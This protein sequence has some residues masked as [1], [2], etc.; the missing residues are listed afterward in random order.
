MKSLR[1]YIEYAELCELAA[2]GNVGIMELIR[3]NKFATPE[4]KIQLK[5]MILGKKTSDAWKLIQTVTGVKLI[6]KEFE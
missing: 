6:G 4:Q 1:E 2:Q 3:F 5:N